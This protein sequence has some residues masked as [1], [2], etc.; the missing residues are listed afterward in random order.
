MKFLYLLLLSIIVSLSIHDDTKAHEVFIIKDTTNHCSEDS[1]IKRIRELTYYYVNKEYP[2]L[3]NKDLSFKKE[4]GAILKELLNKEVKD[5]ILHTISIEFRGCKFKNADLINIKNELIK[6]GKQSPSDK[7]SEDKTN[8]TKGGTSSTNQN[9]N[10]SNTVN[11]TTQDNTVTSTNDN[12][13]ETYSTKFGILICTKPELSSAGLYQIKN[14]RAFKGTDGLYRYY[15][16]EYSSK[17][18]A[19]PFKLQIVSSGCKDAV[20]ELIRGK[21]VPFQ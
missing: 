5:S 18:E 2:D 3:L 14:I 15:S 21:E 16:G 10:S 9:N 13:P 4:K 20:I 6:P 7:S 12:T 11:K 8:S 1:I 19:Y 17:K